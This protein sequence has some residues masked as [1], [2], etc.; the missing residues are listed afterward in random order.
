MA[1]KLQSA[2]V[3][4]AFSPSLHQYLH[5]PL[6]PIFLKTKGK[7]HICCPKTNPRGN[8]FKVT[9]M[10][11]KSFSL[12]ALFIGLTLPWKSSG[13][14]SSP[15]SS[16]G[17]GEL[18]GSG[19]VHNQG[20]GGAGV[21]M[22]KALFLNN[23]N[24]AMLVYSPLTVFN[25]GILLDSRKMSTGTQSEKVTGGNVASLALACPVMYNRGKTRIRWASSIG[26]NPYSTVNYRIRSTL[27][28]PGNP[29]S[30]YI[31]EEKA[32]G[33]FNQ[34]YWS[35][36]VFLGKGLS[37]GLKTAYM[38]SSVIGEFTNQLD[39]DNQLYRYQISM[40]EIISVSGMRFTPAF[41]YRIDSVAGNN[42]LNIGATFDMGKKI[43]GEL[44]QTIVR[45]DLS[46]TALQTDS[47]KLNNSSTYLPSVITGGISFGKAEKWTIAVDYAATKFTGSNAFI[48][49]DAFPVTTGTR[50]SAGAEFIPDARSLTSL[51]KRMSYRTGV[52]MEKSPYLV[53]GAPLKDV[54]INFGFSLPVNRVS[55]LDFAVRAGKRGDKNLNGLTEN[56]FKV[57]FCVTFNDQ[58]FIKSRFD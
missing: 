30:N 49:V 12:L 13:Q 16:F 37:V 20:M 33:G 3:R 56:Y 18:N 29:T 14:A 57:Y 46:G 1:G 28:V 10:I 54:G 26:L 31:Q 27:P 22:P 15:F 25:G 35:N 53:N 19:L 21:S 5:E 2:K 4:V 43:G 8:K 42:F 44:F 7:P 50:L 45:R 9:G 6:A 47:I 38:F 17:L 52:S 58:W 39:L 36:G 23:I 51:L 55:S 48:G 34:I 32:E 40:K 41:H 11:R 24:P